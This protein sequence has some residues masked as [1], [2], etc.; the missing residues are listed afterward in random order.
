MLYAAGLHD[1]LNASWGSFWYIGGPGFFYGGHNARGLPN[2]Q[3]LYDI[4]GGGLGATPARDGVNTG[5]QPNI[6]SG[7]VSDVERIEL[8]YPFLYFTRRHNPD[9][10]GAGRWNGGNGSARLLMVHGSRD[11]SADFV[12]Y[13][14]LPQGAFGLFGGY[15]T[16]IGG[17]RAAFEADGSV[18]GRLQAGDYPIDPEEA[19][20]DGWGTTW[21]PAG[22]AGRVK[23]PEGWLISDFTQG[24][25]GF[26]DPLDREPERVAADVGRRLISRRAAE[27]LHG[28]VIDDDGAVDTMAT[29]ARRATIRAERR[30]G[31]AARDLPD[32][33]SGWEPIM[34]HHALL[35]LGRSDDGGKWIRCSR[36]STVLAPADENPKSA[37]LRRDRDLAELSGRALPDGSAYLGVLREYA[38]PGCATLVEV[39]VYCPSLGG[40]EDL[41]DTRLAL[42]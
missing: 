13:A 8:Q 19:V 32:G 10:G 31:V 35:E 39:N 41:W 27:L 6:P 9:G 16:G 7:G 15:P 26:G 36:C 24:G 29:D 14:G 25:G 28:V 37:C 11:L 23:I 33:V 3:G 38:C 21:T 17:V 12:P 1:D 5:G 4:H 2:P 22:D 42:T 30:T 20:D 34:R 40:E 18:A